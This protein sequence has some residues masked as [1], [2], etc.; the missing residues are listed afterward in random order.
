MSRDFSPE[1]FAKLRNIFDIS[2]L[3]HK[4]N[5]KCEDNG[6]YAPNKHYRPC[7]PSFALHQDSGTTP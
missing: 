2:T 6:I 3:Y 7:H 4:K 5:V 1:T